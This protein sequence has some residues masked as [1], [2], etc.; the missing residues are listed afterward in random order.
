MI[1]GHGIDLQEMEAIESARIKHQGFPKKILTEKEFERYQSLPGRRQ[2]EY[3]AGR[4]SAKEALTKALGTGIGKI[5]FHDIEILNTSKGVPYVTKSPFDGNIWLS[6]SHS[7]NFVQA[8]V[9]L[10]EKDD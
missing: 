2:L 10:E 7:G 3:L 9:I 1:V 6:I 4:W 8:S 5:G